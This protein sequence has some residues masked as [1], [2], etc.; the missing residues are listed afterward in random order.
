MRTIR[1]IVV[2]SI[3]A[4]SLLVMGI[5]L[6]SAEAGNICIDCDGDYVY[7]LTY[8]F[9]E[10]RY[11]VIGNIQ[12]EDATCSGMAYVNSAGHVIIGLNTAWPWETGSYLDP[13]SVVYI[14]LTAGTY[15]ITYFGASS[16]PRDN[17]G[18]AVIVPCGLTSE[19]GPGGGQ[20][21]RD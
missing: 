13:T 5:G 21:N 1:A 14:D 2:S 4:V 9:Q 3:V 6:K 11:S 15:D 7:D 16:S 20:N 18:T 17:Q 12:G 8:V 10:G 19:T